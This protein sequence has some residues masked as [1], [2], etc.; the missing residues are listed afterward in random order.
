MIECVTRGAV[1]AELTHAT[2]DPGTEGLYQLALLLQQ[3][4]LDLVE[5]NATH[6]LVMQCRVAI[7]VVLGEE[8]GGEDGVV[9]VHRLKDVIARG[10]EED[11]DRGDGARGGDFEGTAD[12]THCVC[13]SGGEGRRW[14]GR[15]R[16][17]REGGRE[18][19]RHEHNW[20]CQSGDSPH[21]SSA[22]KPINNCR[23]LQS[24]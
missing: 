2:P 7:G 23:L 9:G 12:E 22:L 16:E 3:F 17:K 4:R 5:R 20:R 21:A 11:A 10:S 18:S 14:G 19:W 6:A 8:G 1:C 24:L 15:L 13:R